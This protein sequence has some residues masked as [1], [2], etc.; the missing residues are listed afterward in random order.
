MGGVRSV[1]VAVECDRC[2]KVETVEDEAQ[3]EFYKKFAH[4]QDR[5]EQMFAALLLSPEGEDKKLD[6]MFEYLCPKCVK[7]ITTY[8]TKIDTSK[9]EANTEKKAGSETKTE[10]P[11]KTEG[12]K[13]RSKG[14]EKPAEEK[15]AANEPPAEESTEASAPD[16]SPGEPG[17]DF[18]EDEL[19][20]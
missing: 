7:S 5:D 6:V 15:P 13:G 20:D 17:E 9:A 16:E 2:K 3:A 19:F 4:R 10:E 11:P 8:I 18:D 14:T 12:K 1:G